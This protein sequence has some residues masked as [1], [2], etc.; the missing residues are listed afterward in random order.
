M[1]NLFKHF[2]VGKISRDKVSLGLN[3]PKGEVIMGM[4]K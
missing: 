2:G 1:I 4:I 3:T